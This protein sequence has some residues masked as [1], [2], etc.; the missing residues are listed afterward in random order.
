MT[1]SLLESRLKD[2]VPKDHHQDIERELA[3]FQS[4][5]QRMSHHEDKIG[6][7]TLNN[8]EIALAPT[9]NQHSEKGFTIIE[10]QCIKAVAI[11]FQVD[12]W[13]QQLDSSISYEENIDEIRKEGEK[14][15]MREIAEYR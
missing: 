15:T 13:L 8:R 5:I 11:K 3:Q 14:R 12:D 6:Q 7:A 4:E 9:A 2:S 10:L 1:L